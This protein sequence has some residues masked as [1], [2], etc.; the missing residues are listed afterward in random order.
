MHVNITCLKFRWARTVHL[1][2]YTINQKVGHVYYTCTCT[3]TC[4]SRLILTGLLSF[5]GFLRSMHTENSNEPL[6]I[7]EKKE[8]INWVYFSHMEYGVHYLESAPPTVQYSTLHVTY[9]WIQSSLKTPPSWDWDIPGGRTQGTWWPSWRDS[10]IRRAIPTKGLNV[11]V[12]TYMHM[13]MYMYTCILI[14]LHL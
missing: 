1:M 6:H 4:P 10:V 8:I 12:H 11:H 13:H 9:L 2:W 14:Q 3:C 7:T 5:H